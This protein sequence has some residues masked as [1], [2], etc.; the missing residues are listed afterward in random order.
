MDIAYVLPYTAA[1]TRKAFKQRIY[2]VLVRM[3]E[4]KYGTPELQ[5]VRKYPGI[6]WRRIWTNLHASVVPNMVK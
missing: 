5:I 2:D 6:P 4:A 3:D 1:D